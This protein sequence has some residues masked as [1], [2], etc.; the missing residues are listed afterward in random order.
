MAPR[1]R[2]GNHVSATSLAGA[3]M[4]PMGWFPERWLVESYPEPDMLAHMAK[5]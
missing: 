5:A 1:Q 2:H 3:L 4:R